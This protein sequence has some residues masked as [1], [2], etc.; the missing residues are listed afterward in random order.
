MKHL[1]AVMI[2]TV[3]FASTMGF[4]LVQG[5]RGWAPVLGLT[6]LLLVIGMFILFKRK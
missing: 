3:A 2:P 5:E 1:L 6:I 4:A